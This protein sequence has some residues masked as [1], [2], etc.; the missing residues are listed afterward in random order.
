MNA[1]ITPRHQKK[2]KLLTIVVPALN[3]SEV[4]EEFY[5]R[6]SIAMNAIQQNYEIV[7]IN[8]GSQ[9]D[10][11]SIMR[12]L[13]D[14]HGIITIVDLSRNFGKEIATTAGIDTAKGDATVIID[15]DLQDPP[16]LIEK[17]IEKW[18][19]GYDVVY[20]Q[21]KNREGETLIKK[22]SAEQFYRLMQKLGPVKLPINTG[23]F[24]MMSKE[25]TEA[26]K[27]LRE[28]NRFMKGIFAWVGFPSVGVSYNRDPRFAGE[29]KWNYTKL[30]NLSIDGITAF[31]TAPLRLAT[32][33]GLFIAGASFL[34]AIFII[35]K[36]LIIGEAVQGFPTLAIFI[37]LLG[38]IQLI[39]LGVIGEYLGRIFS[40]SKNRPLYFTKQV[41]QSKSNKLNDDDGIG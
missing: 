1:S 36:V 14:K 29:T 33:L 19:E 31:T 38:G 2:P 5:D 34:Y 28:H 35:F 37:L 7:F 24:R 41:L 26:V 40:V 17:L 11:L 15:A 21:R 13:Q 3:E 18:S 27:Q 9:D 12:R 25:A 23:D 20:A 6:L 30:W 39:F 10:T 8:D 4:I 22:K 16:E 32:Y